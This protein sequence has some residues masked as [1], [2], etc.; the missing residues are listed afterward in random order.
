[1]IQRSVG[2]SEAEALYGELSERL[3]APDLD[4]VHPPPPRGGGRG[5]MWG[6]EGRPAPLPGRW[7]R[8]G[9]APPGGAYTGL[10]PP[11]R[12]VAVVIVQVRR[13]QPL[14]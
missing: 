4:D 6:A 7:A 5:A 11:H 9:G 13:V 14:G 2:D 12:P 3:D 8:Q 1:M 10:P